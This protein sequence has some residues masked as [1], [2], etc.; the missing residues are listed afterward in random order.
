MRTAWASERPG[1]CCRLSLGA[2]DR[3]P[4]LSEPEGVRRPRRHLFFC[5]STFR[6]RVV[7]SVAE[8]RTM[9]DESSLET[10]PP[11]LPQRPVDLH[12]GDCGRLLLIGGSRGMTGAI[13]M[14]GLAALR[15][16]AGLVT[17]AVPARCAD[18]VAGYH[19]AVRTVALPDDSRGTIDDPFLKALEPWLLA[20]DVV[21]VGPGLGRTNSTATMVERLMARVDLPLVLDADA[22]V[23]A[24]VAGVL[25][26]RSARPRVLTPHLGEFRRLTPTNPSDSRTECEVH[27]DQLANRSG[28]VIVLK[29]AGTF[30]S[31]GQRRYRNGTGNP[32]MATAGSGDV[33]TGLIAALL[34][35]HLS[36][37]EAAVLG[38][39]LHGLAGDLAVADGSQPSLI[40]TDLIEYLPRAF[41]AHGK[42]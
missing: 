7:P 17:L 34:G 1:P 11:S 20:A 31:D 35:Q 18:V 37:F 33:L 2:D 28:A 13:A 15:G 24:G 10:A 21:A 3:G 14:A 16:G 5:N 25:K 9:P 42:S 41:R 22:L 6:T 32:G 27:A 12:K 29:G 38:T 23:P 40:A 19:P 36:P 39:Y 8:T 26:A 4:G 30:V